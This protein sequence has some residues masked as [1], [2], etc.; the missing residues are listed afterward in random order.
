M[1]LKRLLRWRWWLP[2]QTN[3]EGADDGQ[4]RAG[5]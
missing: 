2:R 4:A 5:G 3:S 1:L